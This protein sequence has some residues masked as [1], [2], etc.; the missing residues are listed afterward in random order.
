MNL[1]LTAVLH[2]SS[3]KE[4]PCLNKYSPDLTVTLLA[5]L[6]YWQNMCICKE[7]CWH[8]P[9]GAYLLWKKLPIMCFE[10][11]LLKLTP[12]KVMWGRHILL[13]KAS[14]QFMHSWLWSPDNNTS[15]LAPSITWILDTTRQAHFSPVWHSTHHTDHTYI[16]P[17]A[18][19][20]SHVH[21]SNTSIPCYSFL[22]ILL[23]CW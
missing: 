3:D 21:K 15:L 16:F 19:R 10:D 4:I 11:I 6:Q 18:V 5:K 7:R 12:T 13:R 14:F 22:L 2:C 9:F 8:C 17:S 23:L 1:W 20:S